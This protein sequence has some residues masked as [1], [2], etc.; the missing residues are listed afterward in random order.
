MLE[1]VEFRDV[2]VGPVVAGVEV[3]VVI[4]LMSSLFHPKFRALVILFA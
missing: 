4:V 3:G 1:L 2:A